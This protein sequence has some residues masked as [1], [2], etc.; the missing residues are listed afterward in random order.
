M[1]LGDSVGAPCVIARET[2]STLEWNDRVYGIL[3][4]NLDQI[5]LYKPTTH[6]SPADKGI[7]VAHYRTY[8]EALK[9]ADAWLMKYFYLL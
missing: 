9:E 7:T 2:A 3:S 5:Y 8:K 4:D 1:P 6:M